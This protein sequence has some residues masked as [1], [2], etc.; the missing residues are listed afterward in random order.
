[1]SD[2]WD[3]SVWRTFADP[4]DPSIIYTS[5]SGNLA[6]SL[7]VDWFNPFHGKQQSPV[8][9]GA[10]V[11]VCLNLPPSARYLDKNLF[12]FGIIPGPEEP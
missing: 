3:G 2:V 12:I 11:L 6:F 5:V 9:F 10:I 1:M 7:F 4:T 8:S